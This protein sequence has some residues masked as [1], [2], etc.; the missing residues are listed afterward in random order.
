MLTAATDERAVLTNGDV[1]TKHDAVLEICNDF[2]EL[3]LELRNELG[4]AA[5]TDFV[6]GLTLAGAV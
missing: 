2:L 4:L 5:E 3:H 1:D 6:R